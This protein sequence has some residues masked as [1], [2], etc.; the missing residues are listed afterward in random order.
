MFHNVVMRKRRT[1]GTDGERGRESQVSLSVC[2]QS[3]EIWSTDHIYH[4]NNNFAFFVELCDRRFWAS[5]KKTKQKTPCC[6]DTSQHLPLQK[7]YSDAELTAVMM[8]SGTPEALFGYRSACYFRCHSSETKPGIT[9]ECL[10]PT[11]RMLQDSSESPW[12]TQG[13]AVVKIRATIREVI[14]CAGFFLN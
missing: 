7:C 1:T 3:Y 10:K 9:H 11:E 5:K 12:M 4:F 6:I 2:S 8:P 14:D 13:R